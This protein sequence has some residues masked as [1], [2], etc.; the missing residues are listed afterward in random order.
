MS[1]YTFKQGECKIIENG[2]AYYEDHLHLYVDDFMAGEI[3]EQLVKRLRNKDI[4]MNFP[5]ILSG[6]MTK[7]EEK[8]MKKIKERELISEIEKKLPNFLKLSNGPKIIIL[9]QDAFAAD[10][11]D[12]E[13]V[14]LGK[15]IKYLGISNK[16]IHIVGKNRETLDG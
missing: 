5:I 1:A 3:A 4:S 13:Y 10:Y 6:K 12:E 9:H 2:K 14:L 16:E 15:A 8:H 11:Q 7:L